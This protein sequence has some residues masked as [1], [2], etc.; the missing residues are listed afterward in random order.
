MIFKKSVFHI[1]FLCAASSVS[2][3]SFDSLMSNGYSLAL[4]S[5]VG[6]GNLWMYLQKSHNMYICLNLPGVNRIEE[7]RTVAATG[8][9]SYIDLLRSGAKLIAH[10]RVGNGNEWLTF[11]QGSQT[12]SCLAMPGIYTIE[13]K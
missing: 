5:E 10:N 3:D 11:L 12:V 6:N 8:R 2:A 4:T 1:F 13:C 7:C 9:T